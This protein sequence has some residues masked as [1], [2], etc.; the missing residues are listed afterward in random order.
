MLCDKNLY[1]FYHEKIGN[2]KFKKLLNSTEEIEEKKN[3]L[4]Y[5]YTVM[6]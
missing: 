6:Q 1:D 2:K 5:F 4:Y 3:F